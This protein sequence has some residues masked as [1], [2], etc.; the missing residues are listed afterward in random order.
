[1]I[2]LFTLAVDDDAGVREVVDQSLAL[3]SL[4]AVRACAGGRDAIRTAIEW[5]PDLILLDIMMPVMDGPTTLA[6]LRGDR[7]T[8]TIPVVFMTAR[9]QTREHQR[10]RSLGAA[11][12]IVKPFDPTQLP[13]LVRDCVSLATAPSEDFLQR[14]D[15]ASMALAACRADLAR[16][17]DRRTLTEIKRLAR[18]LADTGHHSGFAGIALESTAL[19]E[20]AAVDLA[21]QGAPM[22]VE[23]ALD[24]VL[25]RIAVH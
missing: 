18:A 1:M 5:R 10:Y 21:G 14:L 11:G 23:H 17:R 6:E 16:A 2:R 20:A 13:V 22:S 15:S 19:A 24:R 8:A 12:V 25:A 7:R 3:D 9:P 4:F